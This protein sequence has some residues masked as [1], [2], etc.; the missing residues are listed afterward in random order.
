MEYTN[1]ELQTI[2]HLH[3]KW[4]YNLEGGAR[5]DL[6][7]ADMRDADLYGA[8]MRGANLRGADMRGANLRGAKN[9]SQVFITR[10]EA[11][12]Y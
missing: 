5:A 3:K 4:L 1:D 7:C 12:N 6:Y 10:A 11:E 2:L 9:I 8:D